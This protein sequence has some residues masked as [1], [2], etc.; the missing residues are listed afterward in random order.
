MKKIL[1]ITAACSFLL[2]GCAT[3]YQKGGRYG[4]RDSQWQ[5][6]VF[7][8]SFQ[9]N[10]KCEP[11]DVQDYTLLR[12]AELCIQNRYKYFE[13]NQTSAGAKIGMYNTGGSA[14][15]YGT[16][17]TIGSTTYGNFNTY[18]SG[19]I[20]APIHKPNFTATITC[21]KEKPGQKVFD[22]KFLG[23]SIAGKHGYTFV[24][25]KVKK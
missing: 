12:C 14:P 1:L 24:D 20:A 13:L 18:D 16:M 17:N 8:V 6:N 10:S 2:C 15:P 9:G 5:E 7:S 4:Y 21:Y 3:P 19:E 25:G 11:Q 22:A 23:K